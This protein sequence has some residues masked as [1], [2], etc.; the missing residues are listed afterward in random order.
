MVGHLPARRGDERPADQELLPVGTVRATATPPG[1]QQGAG[2]RRAQHPRLDLLHA[3]A[4]PALLRVGRGLL[5]PTRRS[6]PAGPQADPS[7]ASDRLHRPRPT[8]T[9]RSVSPVVL[10]AS[11]D[12][13]WPFLHPGRLAVD[14]R[15]PPSRPP[16]NA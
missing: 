11:A 3:P 10:S 8:P 12:R 5:H 2:R 16:R 15:R 9:D 13:T 6:R 4:R 14:E 1:P 7:T